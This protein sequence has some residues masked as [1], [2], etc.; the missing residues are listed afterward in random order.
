[1]IKALLSS[2]ACFALDGA[3]TN[4]AVRRGGALCRPFFLGGCSFLL[5][6]YHLALGIKNPSPPGKIGG[7][8]KILETLVLSSLYRLITTTCALVSWL[9]G[10]SGPYYLSAKNAELLSAAEESKHIKKCLH[11]TK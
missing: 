5:L 10:P 7:V 4:P 8:H 9:Q 1:M 6:C 11:Y 3:S 2:F